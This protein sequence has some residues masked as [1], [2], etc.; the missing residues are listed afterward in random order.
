[1]SLFRYI[2][3]IC[4]FV[5]MLSPSQGQILTGPLV[6]GQA[7]M[8]RYSTL[9]EGVDFSQNLSPN[10]LG[11]WSYTYAVNEALAFHSE[12]VFSQKGKIQ[13]YN[14]SSTRVIEHTTRFQFLD[15]PVLLRITRPFYQKKATWFVNAG[16]QLSYWLGGRGILKTYTFFGSQ[17]TEDQEYK[18]RFSGSKTADEVIVAT[19]ANR[20]QFGLAVGG[21]I[22]LPVNRQGH[23]IMVNVRYVMG[24]T[25][26]TGNESF[27]VGTTDIEEY[28]GYRHNAL[29]LSTAYV[30]PINIMGIRRG[31]S[32]HKVKHR[33]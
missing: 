13:H 4:A 5:L 16:P 17:E 2:P 7:T 12:L 29:Q 20:V 15:A 27:A 25:Q 1:M 30:F 18:I 23:Q 8:V 26:L 9:Y 28:L 19:D 6:G 10:Y 24:T 21:G 14:S 31:K 33:K 3:L 11:G 22:S 32:T